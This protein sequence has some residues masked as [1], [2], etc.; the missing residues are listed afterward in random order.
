MGDSFNVKLLI[1]VGVLMAGSA[2]WLS[3]C[4]FRGSDGSIFLRSAHSNCV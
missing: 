3:R 1:V 2:L 4:F